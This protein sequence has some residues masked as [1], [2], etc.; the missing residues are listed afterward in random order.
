MLTSRRLISRIVLALACA[1]ALHGQELK[2]QPTPFTTW[3]DFQALT[4]A[5]APKSGLPIWI[6]SVQRS[7][8][9]AGRTTYRVRFRHFGGLG[10]DVQFRLFFRDVPGGGPTI[11]GWTETGSQ[12]FAAGPLGQGFGVDTSETLLI[13]A[14]TLDYLD[15]DVA[16]DGRNVRGAFVT[17]L[18]KDAVWHSLDFSAPANL[19]DPFGQ[20]AAG[21]APEDD[22]FLYGRVRATLD[23]EP[24]TLDPAHGT[25][26]SYE[27]AID[28]PPLLAAVTFE[29]LGASP[30]ELPQAFINGQPLGTASI[31]FPDLADPGFRGESRPLEKRMRF[32][33]TGWLRGQ[34]MVPG[35]MLL[36]GA[37]SFTLRVGEDSHP[38]VV[39]A[40]EIEL[41][42]PSAVFD[43]DL[44]P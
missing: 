20:P 21:E 15:V 2:V 1:A 7:N 14:G 36:G 4:R 37:N 39:R 44:K 10:D 24:L 34:V 40:V 19:A 43:Y 31:T 32:R 22:R 9:V 41:K 11:T 18:R 33:Y 16:G 17:S 5:G 23:A 6:E 25:D 35:P 29:I 26:A 42:H 12:P 3:L 27:F 13:P 38:V 28:A 30:A 8:A